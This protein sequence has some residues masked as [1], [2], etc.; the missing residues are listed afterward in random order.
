MKLLL[1]FLLFLQIT[2]Y[3]QLISAWNTITPPNYLI[4]DSTEVIL[5]EFWNEA[6]GDYDY[7]K[8]DYDWF[9]G[10]QKAVLDMISKGELLEDGECAFGAER[11]G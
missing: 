8:V 3:G 11:N 1:M 10:E 5:V 7:D 2:T 6:D 9:E 4:T